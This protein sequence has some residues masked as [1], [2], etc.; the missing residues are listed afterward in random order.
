MLLLL[1]G[2]EALEFVEPV[3]DED[4]PRRRRSLG[5]RSSRA[6]R[7]SG[8]GHWHPLKQFLVPVLDEL[9]AIGS[10]TPK[11]HELTF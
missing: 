10:A 5:R 2:H 1:R 11:H 9:D 6:G 8:S 4:E 7:W 3:L